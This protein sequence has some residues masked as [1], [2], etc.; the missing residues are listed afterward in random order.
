MKENTEITLKD[1]ETVKKM[2]LFTP[3]SDGHYKLSS[4]TFLMWTVC[5]VTDNRLDYLA[6]SRSNA[7]AFLEKG[8]R[9]IIYASCS[10][11]TAS[12][13]ILKMTSLRAGQPLEFSLARNASDDFLGIE[14][15]F[16]FVPEESGDYYVHIECLSQTEDYIWMEVKIRA[17]AWIISKAGEIYGQIF[18]WT[19]ELLTRF[20]SIPYILLLSVIG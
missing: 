17:T 13:K 18:I 20:S 1:L 6:N 5:Q 3:A 11:G 4:D 8:K 9:Y 16:L 12:T 14:E 2:Y 10:E 7:S 15:D 19:K